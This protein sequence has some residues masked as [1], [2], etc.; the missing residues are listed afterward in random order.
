MSVLC[1][2][3]VDVEVIMSNELTSKDLNVRSWG[4]RCLGLRGVQF[5]NGDVLW[6]QKRTS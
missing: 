5:F 6:K 1:C 3:S 4:A 2:C